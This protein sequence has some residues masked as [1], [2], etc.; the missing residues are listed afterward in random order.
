MSYNMKLPTANLY[1]LNTDVLQFYTSCDFITGIPYLTII[2][3]GSV[4]NSAKL[5]ILFGYKLP[6]IYSG[7][8]MIDAKQL[9]KLIKAKAFDNSAND[10]VRIFE[11]Y[12]DSIIGMEKDM[13]K[14]IEERAKIHP[15]FNIHDILDEIVPF[16]QKDLYKTQAPIFYQLRETFQSLPQEI[17]SEFNILMDETSKKIA[18]TPVIVPFSTKEFWY[19]LI[20]IKNDITN[21]N[22]IKSKKVINR[23]IKE[24]KRLALSTNKSTI[25]HQKSVVDFMDL[26]RKK[27][28][29]KDDITLKDLIEI[30][31]ARLENGAVVIPF[32]RKAFIY[33]LAKIVSKINDKT[34]QDK[35][36]QTA[37]KL[38]TSSQNFSAYVLKLACE[39]SEKIGARILWPS[40]A[41]VEH[42]LP[43][44]CGGAN[45]MSNYAGA[46]TR[47]NSMR[48]SI[49]FKE[50]L[51]LRPDCPKF[52]QMYVDRLIELYYEGVFEKHKINPK[53]IVDFKNTIYELSGH[54]VNLDIS[55]L[56]I[57]FS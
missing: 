49:E 48:K 13:V 26:I 1:S 28:V 47:E 55:R 36:M 22:D 6:C 50:Q 32:S 56:K 45:E 20:K 35:I 34:L 33:D 11:S 8:P 4:Q 19:K 7:I 39:S 23:L 5:K 18:R 38:P 3:F 12:E 40:L 25:K 52:C 41:S 17:Q 31:K 21:E 37:V 24:A 29:L 9:T 30:S 42:L 53:Y 54:A 51:K 27:S 44:S 16:Y 46:T 10:V 57:N 14:L 43:R 15:D 2:P